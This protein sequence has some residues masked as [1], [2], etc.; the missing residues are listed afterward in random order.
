M[1]PSLIVLSFCSLSTCLSWDELLVRKHTQPWEEGRG[2]EQTSNFK[3]YVEDQKR[4]LKIYRNIIDI[5]YTILITLTD[6]HL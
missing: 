5:S 4:K 6:I 1:L 3:Y 2:K